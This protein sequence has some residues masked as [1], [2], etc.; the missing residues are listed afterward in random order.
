MTPTNTPI[1]PEFQVAKLNAKGIEKANELTLAFD[2]TLELV[3]TLI[4]EGRHLAI[5][6]TNL[7]DA[8]MHARKALAT[9]PSFVEGAAVATSGR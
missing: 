2:N 9:V 1:N 6:K 8:C 5:V 7:E 3:K 4:P